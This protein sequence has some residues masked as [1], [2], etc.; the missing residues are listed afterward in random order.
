MAGNSSSLAPMISVY[1][2]LA[3]ARELADR[4]LTQATAAVIAAEQEARRQK[5]Y[6]DRVVSPSL[7]DEAAEPKR[8]LSILTVLASTLLAYG[9]GWLIWAGVREHRQD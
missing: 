4:E 8:W 9:I 6:L 1:E 5:L 7:P 2:D 3:L